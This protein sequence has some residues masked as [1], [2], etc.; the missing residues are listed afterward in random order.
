MKKMKIISLIA[1]LLLIFGTSTLVFAQITVKAENAPSTLGTY[2]EMSVGNAVQINLAQPD[3]NQY[4][5]FSNIPLT[6]KSYWRVIDFD[7]SPFAKHFETANIAYEVTY[8][9]NDT[10]TYNYARLTEK[11]L[12][13]IGRGKIHVVGTD[14]T[15][16][17]LS[18]GKRVTPK[19][20]LP[21]TYGD[22]PW[23]SIVEVDTNYFGISAT[24][25]DSSY[26]TIDAWGK[27]KTSFGEFSCLRIRQDHSIMVY[28]PFIIIPYEININY[29]WVTDSSNFGIIATVTGMSDVTNLNPDPNYSTAKSINIMTSFLGTSIQDLSEG[30]VPQEFELF[31]NFPNPFNPRTIIGY[32]LN[33]PS[34][35]T[36]K[37]F[38]IASQEV[39]LLIRTEQSPGKYEIEWN[40][41]YLPSGVYYYQIQANQVLLTKKCLLLK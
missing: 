5:D 19:L 3:S 18:V 4:W 39:A 7:K 28:T 31:Q 35:V 26:N 13:E 17:E 6:Y 2:F 27:I 33:V 32:Q 10:I 21:A 24:V 16:V 14:T 37:V 41:S 22:L 23:S 29:F 40:A 1:E 15:F 34:K 20:H 38:N 8:D 9:N 30:I 12:T 11:D 36:L 25:I